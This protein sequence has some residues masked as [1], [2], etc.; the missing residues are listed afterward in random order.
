MSKLFIFT[1]ILAVLVTL[2][3]SNP[4][5]I[6][7]S[8]DPKDIDFACGAL[9]AKWYCCTFQDFFFGRCGDCR[10]VSEP[11]NCSCRKF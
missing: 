3:I 10:G 4:T 1:V 5:D 2:A 8:I 7:K 11:E 6:V 9:C